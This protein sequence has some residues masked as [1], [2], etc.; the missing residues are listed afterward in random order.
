MF[1]IFPLVQSN[2]HLTLLQP[3]YENWRIFKHNSFSFI[4][5]HEHS[6]KG[7]SDSSLQRDIGC[8]KDIFISISQIKTCYYNVWNTQ[9]IPEYFHKQNITIKY[10][11]NLLNIW[12]IVFKP[13]YFKYLPCKNRDLLEIMRF[14]FFMMR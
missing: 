11:R 4:S 10:C 13:N 3:R 7:R 12:K 8:L 5:S 14:N 2:S 1:Q 6:L 9:S